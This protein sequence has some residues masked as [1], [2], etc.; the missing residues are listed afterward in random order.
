MIARQF[1]HDVPKNPP[2]VAV[3][4]IGLDLDQEMAVP[5]LIDVKTVIG[6][7]TYHRRGQGAYGRLPVGAGAEGAV[8]VGCC[9]GF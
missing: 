7:F 6:C 2:V 9:A 5:V 3:L 1:T 8:D 4:H